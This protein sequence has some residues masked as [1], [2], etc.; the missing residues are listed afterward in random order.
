MPPWYPGPSSPVP[1]LLWPSPISPIILSKPWAAIPG[2][3][4]TGGEVLGL[5]VEDRYGNPSAN[6]DVTFVSLSPENLAICENP[7]ADPALADPGLGNRGC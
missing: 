7:G 4:F 5:I 2:R 6:Q 3:Y 1:S